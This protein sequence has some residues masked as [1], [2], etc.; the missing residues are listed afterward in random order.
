MRA[1]YGCSDLVR[2]VTTTC[3]DRDAQEAGCV[4]DDGGGAGRRGRENTGKTAGSGAGR[5]DGKAIRKISG[6]DACGGGRVRFPTEGGGGV[7]A[8]TKPGTNVPDS[9]PTR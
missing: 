7:D 6:A 3:D 4:G 9:S 1:M 2:S 8:D 5:G